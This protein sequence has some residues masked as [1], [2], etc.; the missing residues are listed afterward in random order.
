MSYARGRFGIEYVPR[1]HIR[2]KSLVAAIFSRLFNFVSYV[3]R[4]KGVVRDNAVAVKWFR[5]AAEQGHARAQ[6]NLG[7][8]YDNG[9]GVSKDESEAVKWYYKAAEQ[10]HV[11]AQFNLG[12]D[13]RHGCGVRQD[14]VEAV[15]WYRMAA[16]QG[17]ADAQ[18]NLGWMYDNGH[19]VS[20]NEPEAV[21]WYRKAAEQGHAHA[22]L[23]SRVA[24]ERTILRD[25][26]VR[27]GRLRE[28]RLAS[29]H[30][31]T[32]LIVRVGS[33]EVPLRWCPAGTFT[34][35][36]PSTEEGRCDD[37]VQHRVTL[38]KGFW[39]G[40]TEVTQGLWKKVMGSNPSHF[41]G[42]DLPVETVSW[43][44]CQAF[45]K[46]VNAALGCGAR[47]PT[48]A[49]W[50]YACRAGAMG[51]YGGTGRLDEMGWFGDNSGGTTHPVGQ[52]KPNSW[53]LC[54]MHGNVWEWCAD[55]EGD[56]PTGSVSDPTGPASGVYRVLRG[57]GWYGSARN[58]RSAHRDGFYHGV[59]YYLNGFRLSCSAGPRGPGAEP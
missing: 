57:G 36:S 43:D 34:M 11:R 27:D 49:E 31:G 41:K 32:R 7:W 16:E 56:Y 5:K 38:T 39:M 53:G 52:K 47:L 4:S 1:T 8:M 51:A 2:S 29:P 44:D 54:D 10:G 45:I 21:K 33:V 24:G 25:L 9:R 42:D 3:F 46:K 59:R 13:Y 40:E 26:P 48:E 23:R 18:N 6:F 37:E 50:E 28:V 58:C 35:G 14:Y 55:W 20:K 17:D 30:A 22:Q 19:G 15:K 12:W